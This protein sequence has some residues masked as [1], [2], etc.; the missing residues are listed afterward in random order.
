MLDIVR[1][2]Y[3]LFHMSIREPIQNCVIM[4]IDNILWPDFFKVA[5]FLTIGHNLAFFS[6]AFQ[7]YLVN[8]ILP[9]LSSATFTSVSHEHLSRSRFCCVFVSNQFFS[10]RK[11][12]QRGLIYFENMN[13]ITGHIIC[14]CGHKQY[15]CLAIYGLL[16]I[17][18]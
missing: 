8:S 15:G 18:K 2:T 16:H 14:Q 7:K 9:F 12:F 13:S 17:P 1:I 5:S 11:L 6:A 10:I 4:P 3:K